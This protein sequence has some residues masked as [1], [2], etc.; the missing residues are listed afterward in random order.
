MTTQES[1][2]PSPRAAFP[3]GRPRTGLA[4]RILERIEGDRLK[5]RPRWEFVFK[6][7]VFWTLGAIAV[8]L[9][10][11]AFAAAVFEVQNAGWNLAA[12]T[13][14]DFLT[15]FLAVAPFLWVIALALFVVLGYANI[16]RTRRG[17][18]Y[19]LAVIALGAV[20]TSVALGSGLY[21]AGL[22]GE[23]EESLGTHLPFYR[24]ILAEE[25][26]WWLA[27]QK[28]LLGGTV[29]SLASSTRMFVLK[30]FSGRVWNVDTSD[31]RGNDLI[32]LSRGGTVR[33]VGVPTTATSSVF[34]ACFVFPWKVVGLMHE[35]A[36][37]PPLF[38]PASSTETATLPPRSEQC[39]GIAPY[40]RL[41]ALDGDGF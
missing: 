3:G 12:A 1:S 36:P 15:F 22:G 5:P 32:V 7:Y 8:A 10:A 16:R 11:F 23:I 39:K 35:E 33:I 6:N 19:P 17:Y 37:T 9:G 20:L 34:H 29:L 14:P 38:V 40:T 30:D 18:R 26:E 28:G 25:H 24:P 31:L 21:A 2:N 13:H 4:A 41:R 27:P